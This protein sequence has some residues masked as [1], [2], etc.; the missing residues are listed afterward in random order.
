[1]VNGPR[2]S[3]RAESLEFQSHGWSIIGMTARGVAFGLV[4]W[5]LIQS[6]VRFDPAKA[7]SLDAALRTVVSQPFG[8]VMLGA[9]AAGLAAFGCFSL[10][11]AR[12]AKT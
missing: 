6:A 2:F 11:E 4:G 12:Y 8:Q 9:I 5:F 3:S 7:K 1:V 10:I